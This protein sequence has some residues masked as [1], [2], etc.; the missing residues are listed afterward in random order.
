VVGGAQPVILAPPGTGPSVVPSANEG[1]APPPSHAP[2]FAGLQNLFMTGVA[3]DLAGVA[4]LAAGL[5]GVRACV[6]SG[7]AGAAAAGNF[8]H[9]A[10]PDEVRALSVEMARRGGVATD[11]LQ[12][13][14]SDIALFLH[15]GVCVAA[16]ISAGSSVPGVRERLARVAELLAGT[17]PAR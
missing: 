13:G 14:E 6:I 10:S 8:S 1:T 2:D 11:T 16:V 7:S 3:L 17:A 5:P 15:D 12:R 9:G 4:A